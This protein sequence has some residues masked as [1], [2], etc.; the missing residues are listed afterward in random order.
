MQ[1][2]PLGVYGLSAAKAE[3]GKHAGGP[4]Q[5]RPHPRPAPAVA[6]YPDT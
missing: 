2:P 5:L 4:P 3:L 6:A 1:F